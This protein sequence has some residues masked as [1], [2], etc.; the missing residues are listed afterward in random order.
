MRLSILPLILALAKSALGAIQFSS[1]AAGQSVATLSFQVTWAD[2]G[3]APLISTLQSWSLILF[4][5]PD[6][7]LKNLGQLAAGTYAANP[8]GILVTI[9]PGIG[10]DVKN[11]YTLGIVS[12]PKTGAGTVTNYSP[13]F[14]LTAMT[15]VFAPV[16]APIAT[17]AAPPSVNAIVAVPAA[18]AAAAQIPDNPA[19]YSVPFMSQTGIWRYAPMQPVP[20]TK[21]VATNTKP[22]FPTSPFNIATTFLPTPSV[23]QTTTQVQTFVVTSHANTAAAASQPADDMQKYLNRWKD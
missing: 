16:L 18:G 9:P 20:P 5:G 12:T 3:V 11:V 6:A 4:A 23:R 19:M 21:I 1:P 8:A 10:D 13:R 22:L 14:S 17:T 7:T 2:D 15:G